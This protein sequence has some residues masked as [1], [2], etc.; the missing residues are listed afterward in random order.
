MIRTVL[1]TA[2]LLALPVAAGAQ[3]APAPATGAP[4]C[5]TLG[6]CPA[7]DAGQNPSSLLFL[8]T[9]L[10]GAAVLVG[11]RSDSPGR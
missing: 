9:G 10:L 7:P 1:A 5:V 2:L 6:F 8:A 11:R 4:D 3:A